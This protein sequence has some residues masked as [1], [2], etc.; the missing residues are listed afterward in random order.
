MAA[1]AAEKF[2]MA[3]IGEIKAVYLI[4]YNYHCKLCIGLL[5]MV[6][7]RLQHI[8]ISTSAFV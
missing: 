2:D 1:A 3:S 6:E 5:L 7:R 8:I 4:K